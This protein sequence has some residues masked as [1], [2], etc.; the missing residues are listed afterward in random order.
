MNNIGVGG[1]RL[2]V[3]GRHGWKGKGNSCGDSKVVDSVSA[4][5]KLVICGGPFLGHFVVNLWSICGQFVAIL[6][7]FCGRFVA[8]LNIIF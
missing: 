3:V 8:V 4:I 1:V 5:S 7:P 6:W 2:R